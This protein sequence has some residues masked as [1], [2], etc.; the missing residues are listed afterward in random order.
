MDI[1][2]STK[3]LKY[4]ISLEG[5]FNIITGLSG[6][7]K[8]AFVKMLNKFLLGVKS[9]NVNVTKDIYKLKKEQIHVLTNETIIEG[10][11]RKLFASCSD[12]LF[13]IDEFS[14]VLHE[15]EIG[16]VLKES[17]NYFIIITRQIMGWLPVSLDSVY[18][19]EMENGCYTNKP[20]Y[21]EQN[22]DLIDIKEDIDYI[23][24]EDGKSSRL[25]FQFFCNNIEVCSRQ[26][27][28]NGRNVER[29]NST[30]HQAFEIDMKKYN[31]ILIVFDA[32]AYA[33]YYDILLDTI[34]GVAHRVSIL[35]WDSFETYLLGCK[36]INCKLTKKDVGCAY[37][38]LEQLA[39]K[40]LEKRNGYAKGNLAKE[41]KSMDYVEYPVREILAID[42]RKQ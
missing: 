2:A 17:K 33:F 25:F 26:F 35:S 15:K 30:L 31:N 32:S 12:E 7:K 6:S 42:K 22:E 36:P 20:L 37:N 34:R 41:F 21:C 28:L 14:P 9:V 5:K 4:S 38:S 39:T 8:T 3:K 29:D 19:L 40:L 11:Y 18:Y 10:D 1:K 24:T 23:L 16:K 27:L 13:I